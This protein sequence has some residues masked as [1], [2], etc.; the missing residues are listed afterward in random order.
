MSGRNTNKATVARPR[1]FAAWTPRAEG[2]A[3]LDAV[4]DILTEYREHLPLTLR[5]VFYRLVAT[6]GYDK[7]EKAYDRLGEMMSRARRAQLIPFDALRDDGFYQ[8]DFIGWAGIEQAKSYLRGMASSYRIDRQ[9]GQEWRLF[10]WCEA[11][12]MVPQLE[13]VA[14]PYSIRVMSSGGFDSVGS[15]HGVA[16][17]FGTHRR[18]TVLH[19]GDHDPSGVHIFS[20][21]DE[22]VGAFLHSMGGCANFIRLAVT[23]EHVDQY[24]LETAPP[25]PTDNRAF[26]GETVQA[27]SL[28]PDI[29][30]DIV[31]AAIEANIDGKAYEAALARE[32]RER[33]QLIEWLDGDR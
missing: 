8:T 18:V 17:V 26:S 3:L 27:E 13:S 32:T 9:L 12:G 4:K 22:D 28:P 6:Q 15:K 10:I 5:Q 1:G 7:T 14:E 23:P 19:V 11:R 29:L 33:E 30:A 24:G 16:Q 20:S 2:Q 25:K 21:L 31:R